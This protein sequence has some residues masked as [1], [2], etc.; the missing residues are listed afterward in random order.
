MTN[1]QDNTGR[2][3]DCDLI[4][5]GGVTSGIVYPGAIGAIAHRYRLR[6]IG[7]T[8]AGAI[9]AAAAAAMEYGL[10][11]GRNAQA[12]EQMMWLSRQTAQQTSNG[13]SFLQALFQPDPAT[14]AILHLALPGPDG[15][16]GA[17]LALF[18]PAVAGWLALVLLP[19]VIVALAFAG[20]PL[21]WSPAAAALIG[22]A[23]TALLVL[24]SIGGFARRQLE[25][26][27]AAIVDNGMGLMTGMAASGARL[28][29]KPVPGLTQW[30]HETVQ[31]LAGRA[32]GKA[33]DVLTF[34]DLW[35]VD[36]DAEVSA[37][38][39]RGID[40]VLVCTD[41]NRLQSVSFPFLP[42]NHRLFYDPRDWARLFPADVLTAMEPCAWPICDAAMPSGLGYTAE[43]VRAAAAPLGDLGQHLRLLPKGKDL[44]IIVGA[45]ASMAFPGL[46]TPLPLWLLRWVGKPEVPDERRPILS[47]LYLSDGGITSNFPIHL[48]DG[49]VP[50]RPTFALNLL[51]PGDDLSIEE[52]RDRDAERS[53]ARPGNVRTL[54]G[55]DERMAEAGLIDLIMPFA[56]SDRVRFYKAP[57]SGN[58]VAQLAGLAM[59][60]VE[61]ARTWADVSHFDQTGTRDRVIHIRLTGAEGGF[62]LAMDAA[63]IASIDNKGSM[64]GTVLASRFDPHQPSDPL[65]QDG[66]PRFQLDW[67][68][69]RQ[70][71]LNGFI[72]A[73][74]LLASRFHDSWQPQPPAGVQISNPLT[75]DLLTPGSHFAGVALHLDAMGSL[76]VPD[77]DPLDRVRRPMSVL[78]MRPSTNDPRATQRP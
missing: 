6:S 73:Q 61:T 12:R 38:S 23:S 21:H 75:R 26:L 62:N 9:A 58:A 66:P 5:K 34:G 17:L 45:R 41:L 11:S 44:P 15:R 48:F 13:R 57:A 65:D 36:S 56:N 32:G 46:F 37:R 35:T 10:R 55:T 33:A 40:L 60:V 8:S 1:A 77:P 67:T 16:L 47:P 29:G 54:G 24:V 64:A 20:G 25:R 63:T 22:L 19:G 72:A 2:N 18:G 68:N 42:E 4:M 3:L 76:P 70:V 7:G 31:S 52:Y 51:Y 59:R 43:E 14:S 39:A 49:A 27:A 50:S 30:L 78:R 53:R 74:D 69:H 71:R 28:D